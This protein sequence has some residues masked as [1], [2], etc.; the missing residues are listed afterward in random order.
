MRKLSM[1]PS[2]MPKRSRRIGWNRSSLATR[3]WWQCQP[4]KLRSMFITR[5]SM[6]L[7]L[8]WRRPSKFKR[9]VKNTRWKK[10]FLFNLKNMIIS[11]LF[12]C[13]RF[14]ETLYF[15][16]LLFFNFTEFLIWNIDST[17]LWV[18]KIRQFE[19]E[20]SNQF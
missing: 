2:T 1:T 18:E 7:Y 12:F 11:Y 20:T 15:F 10:T 19:F 5:I 3:G 6:D 16:K 13:N 9:H 14:V 17:Q 4:L 8:M